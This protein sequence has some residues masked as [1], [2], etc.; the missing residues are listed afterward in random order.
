MRFQNPKMTYNYVG[1]WWGLIRDDGWVYYTLDIQAIFL[2]RWTVFGWYISGVQIPNLSRWP[3]MFRDQMSVEIYSPQSLAASFP[4][5]NGE[6]GRRS[7]PIGFWSLFRG[8][9]LNFGGLDVR[10][11]VKNSSQ[12]KGPPLAFWKPVQAYTSIHIAVT[13]IQNVWT[14]R[15]ASLRPICGPKLVHEF[16]T[17]KSHFRST[18]SQWSSRAPKRCLG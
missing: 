14:P 11:I 18:W 6:K 2:L 1:E 12:N 10:V 15:P 3:W 17:P 16:W 13:V 9:L 5:Q 4:L 8:D 7:F